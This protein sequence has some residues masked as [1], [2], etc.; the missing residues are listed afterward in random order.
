MGSS[1]TDMP[2][3]YRTDCDGLNLDAVLDVGIVGIIGVL[4]LED[5]LTAEGVD[6]GGAAWVR[7]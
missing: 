6:K 4:V 7:C 3:Q 1:L 5:V 2:G